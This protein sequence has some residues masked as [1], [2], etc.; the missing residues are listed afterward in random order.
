P[1]TGPLA[2][3]RL[4]DDP[5]PA[6]PLAKATAPSPAAAPANRD[7]IQPPMRM[8][9]TSISCQ[10]TTGGTRW[11]YALAATQSGTI[12]S[13]ARATARGYDVDTPR[14]LYVKNAKAFSS[15][16]AAPPLNHPHG[17]ACSA[18]R[19]IRGR[20]FPQPAPYTLGG[21]GISGDSI[22]ER[23]VL[24]QDRQKKWRRAAWH[25][26]TRWPC[27]N[28]GQGQHRCGGVGFVP[29]YCVSEAT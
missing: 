27:P 9:N 14:G 25:Y 11:K 23:P 22:K 2:P 26:A 1:A 10:S 24:R 19:A 21:I 15:P 13:R 8:P 28:R 12:L 5:A 7:A 18:L 29:A 17:R 16:K 4:T 20:S 3:A 6:D